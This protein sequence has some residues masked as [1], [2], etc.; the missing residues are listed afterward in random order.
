MDCP[1]NRNAWLAPILGLVAAGS[2]CAHRREVVYPPAPARVQ[3]GPG[4]HVRAP[5]V[6]V[7]GQGPPRR[8]EVDDLD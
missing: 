8:I 2:G 5:F 3:A 6:N 4:V 1:R 7:N